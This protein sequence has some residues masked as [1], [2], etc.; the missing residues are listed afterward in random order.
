VKEV[1]YRRRA[2]GRYQVF[3]QL[4]SHK[5]YADSLGRETKAPLR[6]YVDVAVCGAKDQVLYRQRVRLDHNRQELRLTLPTAPT[7]AAVD[8]DLLLIDRKREDNAKDVVAI[9]GG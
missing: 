4:E 7:R 5:Y 3:L 2:E 1:A 8:P 9:G 6:D